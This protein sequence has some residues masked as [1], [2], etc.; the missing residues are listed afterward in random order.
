MVQAAAASA[1]MQIV[2]ATDNALNALNSLIDETSALS[3]TGSPGP[4]SGSA[5][6]ALCPDPERP[7]AELIP[8]SGRVLGPLPW[9]SDRQAV[10]PA[11]RGVDCRPDPP[12]VRQLHLGSHRPAPTSE[13]GWYRGYRRRWPALAW[14]PGN[15]QPSFASGL[16]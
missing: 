6:V 11:A 9:P 1:P 8:D 4:V 15:P 10:A 14:H 5:G 3:W 12:A 2:T 13:C 7:F 16:A